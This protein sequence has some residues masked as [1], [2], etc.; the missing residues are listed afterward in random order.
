MEQ[1]LIK[2]IWEGEISDIFFNMHEITQPSKP[3]ILKFR[4]IILSS[5]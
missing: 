4:K 3:K 2:N 1:H 5:Y